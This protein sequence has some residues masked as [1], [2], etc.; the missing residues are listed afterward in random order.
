MTDIAH[1]PGPWELGPMHRSVRPPTA[2]VLGGNGPVND[3]YAIC[4]VYGDTQRPANA[5]LITAAPELLTALDAAVCWI[6]SLSDWAGTGDPDLDA[7]R[8]ALAKARGE[9]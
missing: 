9:V 1:T 4:A 2:L 7:S 3:G 8:E 5:R 6:A